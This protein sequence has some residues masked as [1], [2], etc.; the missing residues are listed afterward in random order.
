MIRLVREFTAT[1]TASGFVTR[2]IEEAAVQS[3]VAPPGG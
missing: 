3:A 2:A 1:A